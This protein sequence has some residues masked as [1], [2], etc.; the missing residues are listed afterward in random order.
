MLLTL[1]MF[2]AAPPLTAVACSPD[3]K[4]IAAGFRGEVRFLDAAT[5]DTLRTLPLKRGRVTALA[6]A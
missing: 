1:L 3:G 6:Y 2:V 4:Q 5:G